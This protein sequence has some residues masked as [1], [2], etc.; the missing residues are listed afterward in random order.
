MSGIIDNIVDTK[1][2][3]IYKNISTMDWEA[4]QTEKIGYPHFMLKEIFEQPRALRDTL[5]GRIK[6]NRVDFAE[7][8]LGDFFVDVKKIFI[9]GCGTAYHVGTIGKY[10][11]EKLARV[12]VEVEIA[13]EFGCR[14]VLMPEGSV[15][16]VVS[17]SGETAET[18]AILR[19]TK[20][21]GIKVLAIT[22]VV[23][24]SAARE[25]DAVLYTWAGPE[26][27]VASTKAYNAQVLLM[28]LIGLFI[29]DM[30]A[31][32]PPATIEEMI[33]ELVTIPE[34]IELVLQGASQVET[35]ANKYHQISNTFYLGRGLDSMVAREGALKL[36]ETSYI[37]AEAYPA[38]ELKHGP[39]ALIEEG[40]LV[41]VLA[42][43]EDLEEK[44]R[45]SIKAI[46]A[47]KGNIIGI[48]KVEMAETIEEC[49]DVFTI[50]P[51]SQIFAS[52]LSVVPL[53]LLAYY[54]ALARG[55]N[56]DQPRNLTK[57]VTV[58]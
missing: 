35:I 5:R 4:I 38:G 14:D 31:T 53:Q 24:S 10:V 18:L 42:T 32:L 36:K 17:Q 3:D 9:V 19:E 37:H 44:T 47:K 39:L 41:I 25:A 28:Y 16:I 26:I 33:K 49:D 45:S 21:R 50:P 56:V 43:Q 51:V 58:E 20:K 8:R 11:I 15:L 22:N 48:T 29:A 1:V 57:A 7:D 27:A 6:E 54:M 23:G 40:V 2:N 34:K 46:K 52:L 55:C 12:P 13:S 30:R